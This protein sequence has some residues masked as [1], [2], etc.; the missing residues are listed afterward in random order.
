MEEG[1]LRQWDKVRD[2]KIEIESKRDMK[3]R[4]GRSPDLMDSLAIC[5]EGARQRGFQISKL[6]QPASTKADP[7][8]LDRFAGEYGT[9]LAK[10]TE[11][12]LLT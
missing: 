7:D 10:R 11:I 2:G 1:A 4:V 3:E 8:W 5:V 12:K 9:M 6:A